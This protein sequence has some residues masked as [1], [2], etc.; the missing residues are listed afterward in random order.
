MDPAEAAGFAVD[1][2]ELPPNSWEVERT[3]REAAVACPTAAWV[4]GASIIGPG[5]GLGFAS[6]KKLEGD[7]MGPGRAT[8][9]TLGSI[10][11]GACATPA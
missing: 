1:P 2:F 7:R 3:R 10:L 8:A 11:A 9:L 6:L 5:M 4:D